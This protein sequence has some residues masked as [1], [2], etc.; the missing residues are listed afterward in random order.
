MSGYSVDV[1]STHL[2][3]SGNVFAGPARVLAIY[4]CSEGALG[5]IVIRDGSVSATVIA[6]FDV[7]VGGTSAGE[8]AVYQIEVPGNGLYCP[9]GAYAQLTGGVD[10]VT[11]FYG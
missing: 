6:T 9:N 4:Y 2:T 10:K 1:K 7:P 5:T 3:A 8:P 11:V